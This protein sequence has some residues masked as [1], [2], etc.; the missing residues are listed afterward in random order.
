MKTMILVWGASERGKSQSI[1][2]LA[3][4]FPFDTIIKP[5][6]D[7]DYDSYIIGTVED[8]EGRERIIGIEN[9]GDP[10]SKQKEWVK[11]CIDANCDIIVAACRSYGQTK[12]NVY[13]LGN[14]NGYYVIEATTLFYENGPTL[15]NGIDLRDAFAEKMTLLIMRCLN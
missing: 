12:E 2:R 7:D 14:D 1:K 10:N 6:N 9:Q 3:I 4:S 15:P 8:E 13:Q 5:W 11:A